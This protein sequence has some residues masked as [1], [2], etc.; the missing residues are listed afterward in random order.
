MLYLTECLEAE[1]D[2]FEHDQHLINGALE[3]QLETMSRL[4]GL[5]RDAA[6]HLEVLTRPW[7]ARRLGLDDV[8][9]LGLGRVVRDI[10]DHTD[11]RAA[12]LA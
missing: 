6:D 5:T 12:D 8:Q 11:P 2:S 9:L 10:V 4:R 1:D 7:A 3:R